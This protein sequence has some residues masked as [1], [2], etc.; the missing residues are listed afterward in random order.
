MSS[1]PPLIEG[2]LD[3]AAYPHPTGPIKLVETHISWVFLT[4]D[5]AYKLKKPV[6]LGFLDFSTL[7]ARRACCQEE[8]RLNGRFAPELYLA[9]VPITGPVNR[10]Q[11]EGAGEPLEWAV[12]LRQFNEADQLDRLLEAG[13]LSPADCEQLA[14][15]IAG[16]AERLA[17]ADPQQPWGSPQL[18]LSTVELNFEQLVSA[19][20]ETAGRAE[21]LRGWLAA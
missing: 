3:P 17:V 21:Q 5:Y 19:R 6:S 13:K 12:K 4:G 15:E 1:L 16:V 8:L 2:L 18:F 7:Q 20:P 11:V 10:P 9:G 14:V